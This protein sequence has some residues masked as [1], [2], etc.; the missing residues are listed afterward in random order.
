MNNEPWTSERIVSQV[1]PLVGQ[2]LEALADREPR[3]QAVS[4]RACRRPVGGSEAVQ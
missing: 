1:L 4:M 3:A 2:A